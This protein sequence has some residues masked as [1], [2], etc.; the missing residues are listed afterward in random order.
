MRDRAY[1]PR[2]AGRRNVKV[3][4]QAKGTNPDA[5]GHKVPN[6]DGDTFER[7]A[8]VIT[9]GGAE[10]R[11]FDQLRA[12]V[13]HIVYLVYDS[14]TRGITPADFRLK[15]GDRVL[16]IGAA[17]DIDQAHAEIELHCTEIMKPRHCTTRL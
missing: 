12:E 10:N 2:G 9:R 3:V 11:R 5:T 6:W 14:R 13:S 16:N 4:I 1:K 17:F 15:L 8:A 7:S